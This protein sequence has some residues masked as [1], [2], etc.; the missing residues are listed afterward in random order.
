MVDFKFYIL[1]NFIFQETVGEHVIMENQLLDA[2]NKKSL[3]VVQIFLF[4]IKSKFGMRVF[5]YYELLN[6]LF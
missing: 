1:T 4:M 6:K 5:G 2:E 3:E